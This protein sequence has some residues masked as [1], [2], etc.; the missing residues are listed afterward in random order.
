MC[1][2][3]LALLTNIYDVV[4]T[5]VHSR[6]K[7]GTTRHRQ[8]L[9]TA[10]E[11]DPNSVDFTREHTAEL[12]YLLEHFLCELPDPLLTLKLQELFS[13]ATCEFERFFPSY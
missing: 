10:L 9:I 4:D 12:T 13:S 8:A 11:R 6:N 7:R 1:C 2:I 5:K 3:G